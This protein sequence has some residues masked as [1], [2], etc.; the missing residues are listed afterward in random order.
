M[1]D[2]TLSSKIINNIVENLEDE[3]VSIR[4]VLDGVDLN[5]S[6]LGSIELIVSC[7]IG[8]DDI[9]I[10][11]TLSNDF[12]S[13]PKEMEHI[14]LRLLDNTECQSSLEAAFD[15]IIINKDLLDLED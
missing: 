12:L 4:D 8:E 1:Q 11:E 15:K 9:T 2:L 6:S 10:T 5:I 14:I 7:E 13:N 3:W